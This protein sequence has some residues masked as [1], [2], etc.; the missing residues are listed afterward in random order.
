MKDQLALIALSGTPPRSIVVQTKAGND[1]ENSQALPP[2][3]DN[4]RVI[5]RM[6][7]RFAGQWQRRTV[8]TGTYNCAGHVWASRRT[9]IYEKPEWTKVLS[10]DG[11]RQISDEEI[12]IGDLALY[13]LEGRFL[14]V[15]LI[16]QI[17]YV[18]NS[19]VPRLLSK[20]SDFSGEY[21]HRL[22]EIDL[23]AFPNYEI[24]FWTDRT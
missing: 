2:S 19:R 12:F 10:D 9:S 5:A 11:Y 14:H 23:A 24:S 3:A 13:A 15:A 1:I 20:F 22:R 8:A 17:Q 16:V 4:L 18:G 6:E 7:E 21:L